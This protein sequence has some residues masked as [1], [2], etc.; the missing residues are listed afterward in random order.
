MRDPHTTPEPLLVLTGMLYLIPAWIGW[1]SGFHPSALS[2]L[3]LAFT[4]MSFHWFR[5]DWLFYL[6]VIAIFIYSL[7]GLHSSYK[8]GVAS[9]AL[10]VFVIGYAVFVYI[11]GQQYS[12]LAFD[13]EWNTQQFFHGLI[14]VF[15]CYAF[16]H[17][18]QKRLENGEGVCK[19]ELPT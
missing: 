4:S 6:D 7:F 5:T 19:L 16:V 12:I 13:P 8:A 11:V 15:C 1:E 17:S 2:S 3:F 10:Y 18:Y 9:N 14:H